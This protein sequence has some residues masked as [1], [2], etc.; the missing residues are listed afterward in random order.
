M[1]KNTKKAPINK[2][3]TRNIAAQKA[4]VISVRGTITDNQGSSIPNVSVVE[5]GTDNGV[6]SDNE[7]NYSIVV[8]DPN[9]VLVFSSVGYS[10]QEISV[11]NRTTINVIMED[12]IQALGDIIVMGYASQSKS[13]LTGAVSTVN[14][15]DI[16]DLPATSVAEALQGRVAGVQVVKDS[17]EPGSASDIVIRGGGSVN[18]MAPLFIVDG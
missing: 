7:G 6:A 1:K 5:K 8:S 9:S 10:Q 2:N 18:G 13:D 3:V 4:I 14:S 11:G 17:G 16:N 12:D 15:E